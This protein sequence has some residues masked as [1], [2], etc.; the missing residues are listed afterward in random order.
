MYGAI[1]FCPVPPKIQPR[2]VS[3]AD[4]D[5]ADAPEP[6]S[7]RSW[8]DVDG[9]GPPE[10]RYV[11]GSVMS[12]AVIIPVCAWP[13]ERSALAES[14]SVQRSRECGDLLP[15]M[16]QGIHHATVG[17]HVDDHRF[18]KIGR[19]RRSGGSGTG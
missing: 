10:L 7:A 12:K 14:R 17:I 11:L 13:P 4:P 8:I 18:A 2:V 1:A 6:Y 5:P 9:A 15:G 16:A 19:K 3:T